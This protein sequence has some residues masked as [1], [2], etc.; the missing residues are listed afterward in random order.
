MRNVPLARFDAL[1]QRVL[2]IR[3]D[4]P[5]ATRLDWHR[6]RRSQLLY[7]ATGV[8]QVE[9]RSGKW[10]VP[11]QRA[12]WIPAQE[13]HRVSMR[14]VSTCSLYIQPE[15]VCRTPST[16]EAIA[17]S[18]LMR[19]LLLAASEVAIPHDEHGRDGALMDLLLHEIRLAPALPLHLPMPEDEPL[20]GLCRAFLARPDA[21]LTAAACARKLH[22]SE[23]SFRRRFR[24]QTGMVFLDWRGRACVLQSLPRLAAG[25]SVTRVALDAGY[26]SASAFSSAFRRILGCP[27]SHYLP[28]KPLKGR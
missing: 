1:P 27:P 19:Q 18:T 24:R 15:I 17:V 20:R 21:H 25:E 6:H 22:W 11:P 8:M 12:V 4:Y 16:C 5:P 13:S 28:C 2:P 23:R 26:D 10:T 9:T 3:T 14:D 7:G